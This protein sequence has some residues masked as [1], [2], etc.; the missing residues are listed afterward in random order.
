MPFCSECGA[1]VRADDSFCKRCGARLM[2]SRLEVSPEVVSPVVEERPAVALPLRIVSWTRPVAEGTVFSLG[3]SVIFLVVSLA[4][5]KD[6]VPFSWFYVKPLGWVWVAIVAVGAA[7][8]AKDGREQ[9]FILG[10]ITGGIVG[11][12]YPLI[13][14]AIFGGGLASFKYSLG[15]VLFGA[16]AGIFAGLF[17]GILGSPVIVR[18]PTRQKRVVTG[19]MAIM[20]LVGV[21]FLSLPGTDAEDHFRLGLKFFRFEMHSM[22]AKEFEKSIRLNPYSPTPHNNLGICYLQLGLIEEAIREWKTAKYLDPTFLD[23]RENLVK[24]FRALGRDEEL[25]AE[26]GELARLYWAMN[27]VEKAVETAR[28]ALE[29]DPRNEDANWVLKRFREGRR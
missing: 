21:V 15:S 17:A 1:E 14:Y 11:L 9:G 6:Y 28:A 25:S 24:V 29:I 23:P 20:T 5:S 27:E 10:G 3:L 26:L 7:W 16:A 2:V 13:E 19:I 12:L 4:F 18:F 8:A 22:A